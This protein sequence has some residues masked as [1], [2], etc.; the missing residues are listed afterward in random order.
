MRK[1]G[2]S[3][4]RAEGYAVPWSAT[5][6]RLNIQFDKSV[7]DIL[8]ETASAMG[9]STGQLVRDLVEDGLVKIGPHS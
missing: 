5:G 7:F 8:S 4:A 9:L 1:M 6:R 3:A 2:R